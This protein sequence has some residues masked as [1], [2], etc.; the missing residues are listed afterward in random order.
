ME[1]SFKSLWTRVIFWWQCDQDGMCPVCGTPYYHCPCIGPT[2]DD[3]EYMDRAGVLY[4]RR[5]T[6][7][8]DADPEYLA[9]PVPTT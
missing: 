1:L 5:V 8:P 3:V 7:D 2:E 9:P 4:G 6:P